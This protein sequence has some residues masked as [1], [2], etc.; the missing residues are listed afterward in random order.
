MVTVGN[1]IGMMI[2]IVVVMLVAVIGADLSAGYGID[3][4]DDS[5]ER[6]WGRKP[7]VLQDWRMQ[8]N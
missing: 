8:L 1:I 3:G 6:E 5:K 7:S 4:R 2:V